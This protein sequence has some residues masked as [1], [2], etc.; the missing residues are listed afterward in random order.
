VTSPTL[1]PKALHIVLNGVAEDSRV[2]KCAWSLGNAGWD[3]LVIGATPFYHK[4]SMTIGYANILRLPL[5]VVVSQDLI[6]KI[7]RRLRYYKRRLEARTIGKRA[8]W[9]PNYKRALGSIRIIA[10]EMKPDVVHAHD[11]TALPI[12]GAI[13]A[14][15]RKQGHD[16]K[17]IYDAHEY[18]PGVSH[19]TKPLSN[20]YAVQERK[21][22]KSAATVLSVSEGM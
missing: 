3:V 11:Y 18:V 4:D 8:P 16:A 7:L 14:D 17:L 1:N 22:V 19:L 2:L 5:K 6:A 12:A 21:F 15:L 10:Q 20:L 9:I 13:V